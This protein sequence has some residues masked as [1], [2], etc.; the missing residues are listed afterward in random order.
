MGWTCSSCGGAAVKV[1]EASP[2]LDERYAV[3]FCDRCTP[4][5]VFDPRTKRTKPLTRSTVP[6]VRGPDTAHRI[7]AER[8]RLRR[9]RQIIAKAK[10]DAEHEQRAAILA[11]YAAE[12]EARRVAG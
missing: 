6:L 10:N 9:E 11:R 3:G 8:A 12:A 1:N 4:E 7:V 5:P 2:S